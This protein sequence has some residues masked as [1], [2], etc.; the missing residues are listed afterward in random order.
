MPDV[1]SQALPTLDRH[2]ESSNW[3]EKA[4]G[5]PDYIERIAKHINSTTKSISTS[6][7]SAINT[8]KR[9]AAGGTVLEHGGALVS[10]DT[11]AKAAAALAQWEAMKAKSHLSDDED[12]DLVLAQMIEDEILGVDLSVSDDF[13]ILL[14]Q[15]REAEGIGLDTDRKVWFTVSSVTD[16]Q[17]LML[18]VN[19]HITFDWDPNDHPRD[20][21]GQFRKLLGAASG[22]TK[23]SLPSGRNVT[24]K[25]KGGR[26][27]EY[28]VHEPGSG[29][30]ISGFTNAVQA[31]R[32]I[33]DADAKST[34][35]GSLGAEA[36]HSFD[37]LEKMGTLRPHHAATGPIKVG[38]KLHHRDT[39]PEFIGTPNQQM[40]V[41][42]LNDNGTI[43]AVAA[44]AE[45]VGA[46]HMQGVGL[47]GDLAHTP[48]AED[49]RLPS[50]VADKA[51]EITDAAMVDDPNYVAEELKGR[52][53][54]SDD[55]G[56][57]IKTDNGTHH[58]EK[59]PDG[60]WV[61]HSENGDGE[62]RGPTALDA[63]EADH[64]AESTHRGSVEE[65]I[66]TLT[67]TS[68]RHLLQELEAS[69]ADEIPSQEYKDAVVDEA[70]NREWDF[71]E[72][73][74]VYPQSA[75][76]QREEAKVARDDG[77]QVLSPYFS[78]GEDP[79][80]IS[81]YSDKDIRQML[82]DNPDAKDPETQALV[83]EAGAR[84]I[85]I[86]TQDPGESAFTPAQW[87][88]IHADE[89]RSRVEDQ[90]DMSTDEREL[91]REH[92]IRMAKS[93]GDFPADVDKKK[94][95]NALERSREGDNVTIAD[96]GGDAPWVVENRGDKGFNIV[97]PTG[98]SHTE[99]TDVQ[100][101]LKD[102]ML[103]PE[104]PT[105]GSGKPLPPI[106]DMKKAGA[107]M[108]G[109][110]DDV[111]DGSFDDLIHGLGGWKDAYGS[112]DPQQVYEIGADI[113]AVLTD[114]ANDEP[115]GPH[116]DMMNDTLKPW[117]ALFDEKPNVD[118]PE[119]FSLL[120]GL[121]GQTTEKREDLSD[122]EI[123][124]LLERAIANADQD[125]VAYWRKVRTN[126]GT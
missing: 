10:K 91:R 125:M 84:G 50:A 113:A 78:A 122:G 34:D 69:R 90:P 114:Q 20:L 102:E 93:V 80:E 120:K 27:F 88:D 18:G 23:V 119:P 116:R 29:A 71:D 117:A 26:H 61:H 13:D 105:T 126:R 66:A 73:G 123:D 104:E 49:I 55:Q 25:D 37:A 54:S 57:E 31:T 19:T 92:D 67:D 103:F 44:G 43:D 9:W 98:H 75:G 94:L 82:E 64:G 46:E 56:F 68:T 101:V 99:G 53:G 62:G 96:P 97:G 48:N 110:L 58:F 77:M 40:Y 89:E 7:A 74:R 5:L 70:Y 39:S 95:Q 32:D 3:V 65:D 35:P 24:V 47:L 86:N 4:G 12:A 33:L 76:L 106:D 60:D 6:I 72:E 118:K 85:E 14:E 83:E 51:A 124:Q 41:T 112:D 11:Q 1:P 59:Q 87:Q 36:S 16:P 100:G 63:Y 21:F 28:Q 81:A 52:V 15:A 45:G 30:A 115:D 107:D 108:A 2:P 17:E 38:D 121:D 79:A 42:K 8:V 109:L 111:T 22:G